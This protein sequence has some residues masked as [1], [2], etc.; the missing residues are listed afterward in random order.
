VGKHA[1]GEYMQF[2]TKEGKILMRDFNSGEALKL[3]LYIEEV[4][5][6]FYDE[7]FNRAESVQIK[8]ELKFLK[9]EEEGHRKHFEQLY[10][11][12][13]EGSLDNLEDDKLGLLAQKGIFGPI[14][15]IRAE[16]ILCDN[17]EAL[18]FGASVKKRMIAFFNSILDQAQ[19]RE[20][21]HVLEHI[22][23]EEKKHLE[24]LKL[25]MAY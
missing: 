17:A 20:V 19:D 15:K 7:L 11:H 6:K 24:K 4:G 14:R 12:W 16:E 13:G 1:G 3:A 25:L 18:K 23:E 9:D 8:N 5:S 10:Q 21:R 22:I 2:E